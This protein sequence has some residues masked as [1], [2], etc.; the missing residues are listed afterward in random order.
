MR[1]SQ[2][3]AVRAF[4][5]SLLTPF[6]LKGVGFG[7][8]EVGV[9]NKLIGLVLTIVGALLGGALMLRLRLARALFLFGILQM[10]SNLGLWWLAVH[11]KGALPSFLLPPF[12]IGIV[13]LANPTPV[14]GGLLLAV[15]SENLA[16]GMGTA[17]FLAF[18]MSLTNQRFTATQFALLSAFS[19]VGRVWVGPV[20]GVLAE[21]IGWPGF[22][23]V[24]MAL[25]LP[26]LLWL[27]ALWKPIEALDPR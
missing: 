1:T 25:A 26:S 14:D 24:A 16:S 19:S 11:G 9:V 15:A 20:A 10:F 2:F 22:F 5:Q 8:A 23:I 18:L 3:T 4:A 27:A 6:L 12:D 13:R 17:A 7:P 21:S